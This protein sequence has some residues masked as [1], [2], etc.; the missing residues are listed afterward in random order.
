MNG[1]DFNLKLE[2]QIV[3]AIE[4]YLF[5]LHEK[6]L[7]IKAPNFN[8][9]I[10]EKMEGGYAVETSQTLLIPFEKSFPD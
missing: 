4:D 8:L 2:P 1:R 3:K 10:L 5:E 6:P 7:L 9:E